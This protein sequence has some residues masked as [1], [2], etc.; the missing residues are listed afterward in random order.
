MCGRYTQTRVEAIL[1]KRFRFEAG[2]PELHAR[3]NLAPGQ[4]AP[5]VLVSEGA[6]RL[7][8]LRWGLVPSWSKDPT[9]AARRINARSETAAE[10]PTFRDAFARRRCLVLAD[11][12][13][14]WRK[15]AAGPRQPVRFRLRSGEPFAFA[16]LW[17]SWQPPGGSPLR[18]F[19]VLTTEA[20][21]RVRAVHDRMPVLLRPDDEERWLARETS[22]GALRALLRPYEADEMEGDEVSPA[23]SSPRNDDPALIVPVVAA[24]PPRQRSL[25]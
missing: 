18:T 24:P 23:V 17:E 6:R 1:R 13:Y 12:F 14:E 19:T 22:L 16:G 3:Y 2:G 4:D 25:F 8:L 21:E 7:E 20:N 5:V 10:R 15:P 9:D 11:G